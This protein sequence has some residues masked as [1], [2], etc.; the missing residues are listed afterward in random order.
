M[1]EPRC[2]NFDPSGTSPI[3]CGLDRTTAAVTGT[4]PRK[5]VSPSQGAAPAMPQRWIRKAQSGVI[6][7]PPSDRPVEAMERASARRASNH[8]ATMVVAGTKPQKP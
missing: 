5:N 8:R 4:T 7:T 6:S 1:L 2:A 3:S